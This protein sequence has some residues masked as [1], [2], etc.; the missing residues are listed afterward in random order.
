MREST[1]EA[2]FAR[3]VKDLGGQSFK[4]APVVAGN[5]DRIV[6]MPG[7]GVFFVELKAEGGA[8]SPVQRL[9]HKRAADLG[10]VVEVVEGAVAAR[11][12]APPGEW[13][14]PDESAAP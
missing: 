12:W 4:F 1:V 9:W 2:I 7:G 13:A 10:T 11:S 5:P 3:R 8:L 14:S 6:L